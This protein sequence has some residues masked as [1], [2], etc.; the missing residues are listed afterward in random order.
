MPIDY[1]RET[2]HIDILRILM[3]KTITNKTQ[4]RRRDRKSV[5]A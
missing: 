2:R 1:A 3:E 4:T 5:L